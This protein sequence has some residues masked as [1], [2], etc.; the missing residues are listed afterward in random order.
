L[1]AQLLPLTQVAKH[2]ALKPAA[3]RRHAGLASVPPAPPS[4]LAPTFVEVTRA[5][6]VPTT[7]VE[8]QRP[9]GARLHITYRDTAP[10][11]AALVQLFLEPR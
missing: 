5:P 3:L 2:L 10:G 11:L 8:L 9:D 6:T 4:R 7:E 1:K